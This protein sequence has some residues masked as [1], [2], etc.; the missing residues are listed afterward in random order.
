LRGNEQQR[1]VPAPRFKRN[2]SNPVHPR[3]LAIR[4]TCHPISA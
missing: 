4:P 2:Y 3:T 1:D